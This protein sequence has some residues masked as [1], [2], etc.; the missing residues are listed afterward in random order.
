MIHNKFNEH[1][2]DIKYH[3]ERAAY[4][5]Y[6]EYSGQ[7]PRIDV[8]DLIQE[9][10]LYSIRKMPVYD[11]SIAQV[12]SYLTG[13]YG[14]M[15]DYIAGAARA[16][17]V[18]LLDYDVGYD[19]PTEDQIAWHEIESSLTEEEQRLLYMYFVDSMTFQQV[20]DKVGSPRATIEARIKGIRSRLRQKYWDILEVE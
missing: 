4:K 8:D 9:G 2:K 15:K 5:V 7:F 17:G 20:A 13:V 16:S 12:N 19:A 11:E 6:G 3:V 1:Y 18:E 10:I 14:K